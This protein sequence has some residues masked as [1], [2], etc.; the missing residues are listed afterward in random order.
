MSKLIYDAGEMTA[1][2]KGQKSLMFF[3]RKTSAF[4]GGTLA[5]FAA[6]L[7]IPTHPAQAVPPP[8]FIFSITSQLGNIFAIAVVFL[9]GI[10]SAS[11]QFFKGHI[12]KHKKAAIIIGVASILVISGSVAY[13]GNQY[14]VSYKQQQAYKL[15]LEQSK[16]EDNGLASLPGTVSSGG[17]VVE[18]KPDTAFWDQNKDVALSISNDELKTQLQGDTSSF[19]VLD[20]REDLENS[21]GHMPGSL[22]IRF[23]DLADGKWKDLPTN[24]F[25]YALCWSGI[26]GK[27][28]AEFLRTK[29]LVTRYVENGADSWVSAG[30]AWEGEIKFLNVYSADRYKVVFSKE[31]MQGYIKDGVLLVD[32]RQPEKFAKNHVPG[33]VNIPIM[34]TPTPKMNEVFG[35]VPKGA[36]VITLCDDYVNCFDAKLTGVELEKR[37]ATF[38]GR[39]NRPYDFY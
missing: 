37:G 4:L 30:G 20:A 23:A 36:R 14:Y 35:Q 19:I 31:Q 10:F 26:R 5:I 18:T 28:V 6:S 1:S 29:N 16:K 34:Y 12:T 22:H 21:M 8:D 24:K 39:Y 2:K 27:E 15:F 17:G 7:L 25:I 13:F 11:Y 9:S 33:S 3:R 38:L 32:S